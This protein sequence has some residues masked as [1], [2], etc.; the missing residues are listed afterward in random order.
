M[1]YRIDSDDVQWP[2]IVVVTCLLPVRKG[3]AFE[4]KHVM[5]SNSS[6]LSNSVTIICHW[7]GSNL[8]H[9]LN[10]NQC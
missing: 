7:N 8:R 1:V 4:S 3:R 2:S 6:K 9:F 10:N 5:R